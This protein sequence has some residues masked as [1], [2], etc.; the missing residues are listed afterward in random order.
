[1]RAGRSPTL[2][3]GLAL[4][5][6]Y[7]YF[8]APAAWN[9]NSRFNLVRSL[10]ERRRI[11]IDP[12]HRNTG[13]KSIHDGHY[14]SD[15]AP[16]ASFLAVP[17]Y[18][19][20][21]AYLRATG[22]P[23]PDFAVHAASNGRESTPITV[24]PSGAGHDQEEDRILINLSFRKALYVCNLFTNALAGAL[25]G[26]LFYVVLCALGRPQR[27]ALGATLAFSLGTLTFP[28]A[29][30]F[31]G[32]VLA[33]AFLFGAF[34]VVLRAKQ[35][36]AVGGPAI[37]RPSLV[38]VGALVAG[39]VVA[40]FPAAPAA[41]AVAIYALASLGDRRRAGWLA[42]GALGPAML[43]AAYQA[44]AF[45][46]PLRPG[47]ALVSGSEFAAGMSAGLLG[48]TYP[49][50]D[51]LREILF[52]GY[53]G[54]FYV[55]P[56][57]LLA[58][59][60]VVR[61]ARPAAGLRPEGTLACA[62]SA[63]FVLMTS[64]YYMWYGGAALGPRHVIPMLPFLCLGIPW[65]LPSRL[66]GFTIVLAAVSIF[67]QTIATAVAP[68]APLRGDPLF[69]HAYHHFFHGRVAVLAG[70]SNLGLQIGLPGPA[71]L[72]PLAV[73]WFLTLRVVLPS[74]PAAPRDA[75]V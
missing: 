23:L 37:G 31:Y 74:L 44:S 33:A 4:F 61:L 17:P 69:D 70:T 2:L 53:R 9:E 1:M 14:Y 63:Y 62:I 22:R 26:A 12:Y 20:Y 47:Y 25:L 35:S 45:G 59:V 21:Y 13:D 43:L 41:A 10:V 7:A 28:Y 50:P 6:T 24:A 3:V 38:G 60:G 68:E 8:V 16:G 64:A 39:A 57:L 48:I 67:N 42:L 51:V 19:A 11:D 15:K 30:M 36:Q 54:L 56:V 71:S 5:V 29:T 46:N 72:V 18:A 58:C 34:A 40:E 52:G 65:A 55:A 27:T 32:H 75:H 73:I 49:K 66:R